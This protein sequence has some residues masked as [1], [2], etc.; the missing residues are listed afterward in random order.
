MPLLILCDFWCVGDFGC[1]QRSQC[2]RG[3]DQHEACDRESLSEYFNA[4]E[5]VHVLIYVCVH[6]YIYIYICM[7][8]S[9]CICIYVFHFF[10]LVHTYTLTGLYAT[11]LQVQVTLDTGVEAPIDA[12]I[13]LDSQIEPMSTCLNSLTLISNRKHIKAFL[14]RFE[15]DKNN[16]HEASHLYNFIVPSTC[17]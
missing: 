15:Q 11:Y 17:I 8:V 12:T 16:E 1:E 13:I 4:S 9:I 5:G 10:F 14:G 6:I 7:Y 3:G 2:C